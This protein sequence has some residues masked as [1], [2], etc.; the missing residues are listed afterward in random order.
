MWW[1]RPLG[2]P[3]K[4]P[5]HITCSVLLMSEQY[6]AQIYG[7]LWLVEY[8]AIRGLLG[9]F[10][11]CEISLPRPPLQKVSGLDVARCAVHP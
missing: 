8:I 9:G 7:I 3:S 4:L 5:Y 11:V 1:E 6:S 10:I 2:A